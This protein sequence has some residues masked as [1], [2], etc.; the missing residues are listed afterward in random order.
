M[1]AMVIDLPRAPHARAALEDEGLG[2][3]ARLDGLMG[4]GGLSVG[5]RLGDL[6]RFARLMQTQGQGVEATRMLFDMAYANNQLQT[7]LGSDCPPLRELAHQLH[8]QYQR[9]GHWLGLH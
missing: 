7:A 2:F 3:D 8:D 1:A 6:E 9:A 4:L 5:A